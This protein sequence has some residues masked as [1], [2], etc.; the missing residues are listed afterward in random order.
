MAGKDLATKCLVKLL[1]NLLRKLSR[2]L[3]EGHRARPQGS[4][5]R[6]YQRKELEAKGQWI[7]FREG[8][9]LHTAHCPACIF[10]DSQLTCTCSF[11]SHSPDFKLYEDEDLFTVEELDQTVWI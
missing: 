2:H 7:M 8:Q 5:E 4:V 10:G 1:S 9:P 3:R 11:R 6:T